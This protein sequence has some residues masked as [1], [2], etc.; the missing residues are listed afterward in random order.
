MLQRCLVLIL[1]VAAVAASPT[2]NAQGMRLP[3]GSLAPTGRGPSVAVQEQADFIIAVVNSEPITNHELQLKAARAEAQLNQRGA[4]VPPMRELLRYVLEQL[5]NEKAQLQ[6]ARDTGVRVDDLAV[7]QAEEAVA[8]QNQIDVPELRRRLAAD[9]M[10]L[11]GFREDLRNQLMLTRLR[12]REVEGRVRVSDLEVDQYIR[13][14]KTNPDVASSQINIAQVLVAVPDNANEAQIKALE[15]RARRVYERAKAG[16]DFVALVNEYSDSSDR[17]NGGQLG[18][19]TVDRYPPLFVEATQGL[20]V[21]AI[22]GPLR[23]GAGFHILKLI[24]K[25]VGDGLITK[26]NQTRARHILLRASTQVA[27]DAAK[28]RLADYR[29]RIQSGQADFAALAKEH[30][31]DGSASAGGD[32]GW[33]N[34]G[35]FVPE[36]EDVMNALAPGEISQPLASRFGLHL[37]QVLERREQALTAREQREVVRNILREKKLEDAYESWAQEVRGRAYVEFRDA[38]AR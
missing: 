29:R 15:A 23:S 8:R 11:S 27:E 37:I 14:Q 26:V 19:R 18:L 7:D 13:E 35:Q 24:E 30:S 33:A 21:G 1:A 9:G 36:F 22:T 6:L 32:L 5:I 2:V 31:Q 16:E 38:S 28:T 12:E 3:S 4:A 34:P 25:S 20:S 10:T 17:G